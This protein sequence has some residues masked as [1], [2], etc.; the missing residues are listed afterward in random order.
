MKKDSVIGGVKE[1]TVRWNVVEREK[2]VGGQKSIRREGVGK[3][4]GVTA[5]GMA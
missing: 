4:K 3:R 2:S 5:L 1:E